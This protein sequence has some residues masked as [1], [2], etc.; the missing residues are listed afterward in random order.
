MLEVGFT[1]NRSS[2]PNPVNSCHH[3]DMYD[4]ISSSLVNSCH[5]HD[6][7]VFHHLLLNKN[8]K[9]RIKLT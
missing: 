9:I 7:I 2:H 1:E 8:N 5:H 4:C 3:H 6:M